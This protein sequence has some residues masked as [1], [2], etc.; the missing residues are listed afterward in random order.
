MKTRRSRSGGATASM[1]RNMTSRSNNDEA[2]TTTVEP[3]KPSSRR[4][5]KRNS[6]DDNNAKKKVSRTANSPAKKKKQKK[7]EIRT[8]KSST[9]SKNDVAEIDGPWYRMFTKGDEE[10]DTYMATEWGY[11]KRGDVALFEKISLEGAQS[12]LSW[13]TILRKRDAYREVFHNFDINKVAAM[14]DDDVER[15]VNMQ[16]DDNRKL[17]VRHRGKIEAVINNARCIQL[18]YE[19]QDDEQ[20]KLRKKKGKTLDIGKNKKSTDDGT[21]F[22]EFLWSFVDNKP[23]LN[24]WD[25]NLSNADTKTVESESMSKALKKLGFR[26][27]GPTTCYAMMQSV[28]MV[29]D[30]KFGSREWTEAKERLVKRAGGYQDRK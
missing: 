8:S 16:N 5:K 17:V 14:T 21:L 11:E 4:S 9:D 3:P 26:F 12:G 29:I 28:G 30:H 20:G 22:D 27:V 18:M 6:S 2:D 23:I 24:Y 13:L 19:E 1:K 15:I 25:G 7:E 10:Y